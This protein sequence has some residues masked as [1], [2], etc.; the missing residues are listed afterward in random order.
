M[1]LP[2]QWRRRKAPQWKKSN[3]ASK[4]VQGY[5]S[6]AT[7]TWRWYFSCFASNCK[8]QNMIKY[9]KIVK[10]K[11]KVFV[12]RPVVFIAPKE[13]RSLSRAGHRRRSAPPR[14]P[15][16]WTSSEQKTN[17]SS[18]SKFTLLEWP[19]IQLSSCYPL[20]RWPDPIP[21]WQLKPGRAL[22]LD[23]IPSE[24]TCQPG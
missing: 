17:A 9:K 20:T 8:K 22:T 14:N 24:A 16:I 18:P 19:K 23:P 4:M 15:P 2:L 1:I 10:S 11:L 7:L 12:A 3:K 21:H 6:A 5:P 13:D